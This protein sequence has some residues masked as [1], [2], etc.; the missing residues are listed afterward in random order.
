[1]S[2]VA[3]NHCKFSISDFESS[4][5]GPKKY[6][7]SVANLIMEANDIFKS[8][9]GFMMLLSEIVFFLQSSA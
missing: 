1:M 8:M 3:V 5:V 4:P 7:L 6:R 2:E 9:F